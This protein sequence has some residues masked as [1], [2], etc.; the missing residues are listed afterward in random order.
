MPVVKGGI[1]EGIE[2]TSRALTAVVV[3]TLVIV[4]HSDVVSQIVVAEIVELLGTAAVRVGIGDVDGGV[5]TTRGVVCT[6]V[7]C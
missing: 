4:D 2:V 3:W 1:D 7:G 5:A 6:G